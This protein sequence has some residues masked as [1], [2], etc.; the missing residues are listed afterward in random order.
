[1]CFGATTGAFAE[2]TEV[3]QNGTDIVVTGSRVV[4]NGFKSPSP[5]TVLSTADIQRDAPTNIAN[6]VNK[7]PQFNSSTTSQNTANSISDTNA[8]VNNL[9]LRGIGPNRT[10]VL[11]DGVR[12]V[13]SS[14]SGFYLNG[15]AVDVNP[16]PDA[17]VKR[18]DVVTAGASAAYGSDA[19]SGVVNFVLDKDYKGIKGEIVGGLSDYGDDFTYRASLTGGTGFAEDRGHFL[20]SGSYTHNNG[21]LT[22]EKRKWMLNATY[23]L[24]NNPA[25]TATNGQPFLIDAPQNGSA[26]YAPGGLIGSGPLRGTL[27]GVGGSTSMFNYGSPSDGTTMSGGDWLAT[28]TAVSS[29]IGPAISL[30]PSITRKNVF[31]RLSYDLTD[32]IQVYGQFIYSNTKSMGFASAARVPNFTIYSGNPFIPASVQTQMTALGLSSFTMS[33]DVISSIGKVESR[34]SRDFFQY[35]AGAEGKVNVFGSEWSWDGFLTRSTSES[36]VSASHNLIRPRYAL[37]VDV[38]RNPATGMPI[39]RSTLTDPTNGCVP[40]NPMGLGVN[41]QAAINYVSGTS[42]LNQKL[43]QNEAALTDHRSPPVHAHRPK[44]FAKKSRSTTSC[45]ILACS[46]STSLSLTALAASPAPE[47]VLA[48]PSM[49]CRFQAAIIVW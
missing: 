15:G 10:L 19:I 36:N 20:V 13:P 34:S 28:R 49:A 25:Y 11:L 45:P 29:Y 47:K 9:N 31:T 14:I 30:N 46:F 27:F 12:I 22:N 38:V 18:V 24:I 48:I 21:V 3:A 6:F 7:L 40:Y 5:L 8:G 41:S 37:A 26:L 16:F 42:M 2:T 17:L 23:V 33:Q 1:M 32:N 35:L 4:T 43:A 39:C 44:A